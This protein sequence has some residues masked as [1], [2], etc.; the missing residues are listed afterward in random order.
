MSPALAASSASFPSSRRT[1]FE[2]VFVQREIVEHPVWQ[3]TQFWE[4]AFYRRVRCSWVFVF[5]FCLKCS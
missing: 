5:S 1:D 4:E 3:A 2:H